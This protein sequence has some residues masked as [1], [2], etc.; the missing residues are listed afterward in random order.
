M[1]GH[2]EYNSDGWEA[3][4]EMLAVAMVDKVVDSTGET[5]SVTLMLQKG[6]S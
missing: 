3:L 2:G 5:M 6:Y 4:G 1:K